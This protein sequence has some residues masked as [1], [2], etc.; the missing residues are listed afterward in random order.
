[1]NEN[2]AALMVLVGLVLIIG[3]WA[4]WHVGYGAGYSAGCARGRE[5]LDQVMNAL[6][7]KSNPLLREKKE[8]QNV[9]ETK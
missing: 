8:S 4:G 3:V 1:M 6:P 2:I 5:L 7:W 9:T